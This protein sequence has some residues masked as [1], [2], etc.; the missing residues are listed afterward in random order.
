MEA[1]RGQKH[2]SEAKK[3]MKELIYQK[4]YLIKVSQQPQKPLS[5]SNQIWATTSDKKHTS[6]QPQLSPNPRARAKCLLKK[7]AKRD[8]FCSIINSAQNVKNNPQDLFNILFFVFS[9][10]PAFLNVTDIAGLVKGASTGEGL[11]NAFLSHI[12]ACDAMF[13][14]CRK[15]K[16]LIIWQFFE[17]IGSE[18]SIYSNYFR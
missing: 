13:H 2:P 8:S 4:K 17:P 6:Q 12:K 16:L 11:G 10:V 7:P 14:L 3:G 15:Y 18:K 1:V 9:K 5:G